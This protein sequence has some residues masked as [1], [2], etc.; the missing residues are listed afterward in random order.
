MSVTYE[1]FV[2]NLDDLD[3]MS[4]DEVRAFWAAETDG[5]EVPDS[6]KLAGKLYRAG[7]LTKYQAVRV[8]QNKH[9]LLRLGSYLIL[10]QLGRGGM[11]EV[12]N[13]R[14]NQLADSRLV[15]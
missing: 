6:Q 14:Y 15:P 4:A 11:G 12:L 2:Q 1:Q 7:K 3:I 9:Q 13:Q 8:Y 10:D 5:N